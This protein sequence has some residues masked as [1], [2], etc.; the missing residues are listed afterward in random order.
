MQVIAD[1]Y[2]IAGKESFGLTPV[3]DLQ[4]GKMLHVVTET[5]K[6]RYQQ[7][8]RWVGSFFLHPEHGFVAPVRIS[9]RDSELASPAFKEEYGDM[10][11]AFHIMPD[12]RRR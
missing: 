3:K 8:F 10:E 1:R 7:R 5:G 4:T 6:P 9:V 11:E 12:G 2:E